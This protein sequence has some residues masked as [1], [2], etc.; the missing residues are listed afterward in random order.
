VSDG[1]AVR[2]DA[3]GATSAV[4]SRAGDGRVAP[5]EEEAKRRPKVV[6]DHDRTHGGR[7]V[8]SR[9]LPE[10]MIGHALGQSL[11]NGYPWIFENTIFGNEAYS[12]NILDPLQKTI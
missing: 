3:G 8:G 5:E 10:V 11:S 1:A 4:D 6:V 9:A 2:R 12:G 7:S